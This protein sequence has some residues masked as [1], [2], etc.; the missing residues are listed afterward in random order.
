MQ[1]SEAILITAI[2]AGVFMT[3]VYLL[4]QIRR[5]SS[6]VDIGWGLGFFVIA[7]NL[8]L[9]RSGDN[10]LFSLVH[11]LVAIWGLRLT[12]HILLRKAGK[13]EDWRFANWREQWGATHWW[14][15]YLQVF[16]LQGLLMGLLAAPL[17]VAVS[18]DNA[19]IGPLAIVGAMVW[20]IGFGFE[21]IGDYQL[22]KFLARKREQA[23][24][25]K[26]KK[27]KKKQPEF[28]TEGLWRY[29]RH[30]NY[31]GE[32]TLW[33]GLWLMVASVSN[34]IYSIISPL[35]ITILLLKVSGVPMLE[36]KW[37]DNKEFKKYKRRTNA[38]FPGPARKI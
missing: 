18:A 28:M 11:L 9:A 35:V 12:M 38:F 20:L 30:P 2:T 13:P 10:E 27:G 22:T 3:L 33:W 16:L 19:E 37:A 7:L 4:A 8:Y 21:T 24:S 29:T 32:V 14:R 23:A 36:A 6:L 17:V 25:G 15:S 31:F 5:D 26:K 1:T 34:G